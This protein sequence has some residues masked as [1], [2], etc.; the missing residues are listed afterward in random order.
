MQANNDDLKR[1]IRSFG[2]ILILFTVRLAFWAI[3]A[4]LG[5]DGAASL[6]AYPD[7][8]GYLIPA[9]A[10]LTSGRFLN[11]D[12]APEIAR[13]PG[14]PLVI[15]LM[16][17]LFGENYLNALITF[18]LFLSAV[19]VFAFGRTLDRLGV[20]AK[21]RTVL[22]WA[23]ILNPHDA[24]FALFVLTDAITQSLFVFFLAFFIRALQGRNLAQLRDFALAWAFLCAAI[25]VRPSSLYLPIFLLMGLAV[26]YWCERRGLWL[27]VFACAVLL[28]FIPVLGWTLRNRAVTGYSGFSAITEANLYFYH[29]AGVRSAQSGADF[30]Q[31]Q[32]DLLH[33]PIYR[34]NLERMSPPDAQKA[35][36]LP[37]LLNDLPTYIRLHFRG[38]AAILLYPGTFD[39]FRLQNFGIQLIAS[40][41]EMFLSNG[42]SPA[43]AG[44][45]LTDPFGLMSLVNIVILAFLTGMAIRAMIRTLRVGAVD[46]IITCALMGVTLYN[47]LISA[48][49]NGFGTYPRFRLSVSILLLL[50]IGVGSLNRTNV[51]GS[52]P[53]EFSPLRE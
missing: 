36:A 43:L 5:V 29:A 45:L 1:I 18:Q 25:F 35:T 2:F 51:S 8:A 46:R 40:V 17:A 11:G 21:I 19:A 22:V 34:S 6:S 7:S 39:L 41:R 15:A 27:R 28:I 38:M 47:L 9:R 3:W 44:A 14:Y 4:R 50:W 24:Y 48:G 42:L 12:G 26:F 33:D 32:R 49:P 53:E 16:I 23:A 30:Y 10:L 13:T 52:D 37:I 20:S 31:V